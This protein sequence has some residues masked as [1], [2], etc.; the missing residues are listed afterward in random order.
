MYA[1]IFARLHRSPIAWA[2]KF[3]LRGTYLEAGPIYCIYGRLWQGHIPGE[4]HIH[5]CTSRL[6]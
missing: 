5:A 4:A 6:L 1:Q 2:V 3:V